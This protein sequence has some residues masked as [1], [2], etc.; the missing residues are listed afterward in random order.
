MGGAATLK[1]K[2]GR[3]KRTPFVKNSDWNSTVDEVGAIYSGRPETFS[4]ANVLHRIA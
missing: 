2:R 3:H 1:D 4:R